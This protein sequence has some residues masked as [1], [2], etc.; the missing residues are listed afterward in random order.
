MLERVLCLW[1][2]TS[3]GYTQ[4]MGDIA[5][6]ILMILAKYDTDPKQYWFKSL[7]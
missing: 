4:G 1:D 6:L 2:I 5:G 7:K 3:D